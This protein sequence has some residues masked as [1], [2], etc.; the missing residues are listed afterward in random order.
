MRRLFLV[1]ALLLICSACFGSTIRLGLLADLHAGDTTDGASIV[2]QDD[3]FC[4]VFSNWSARLTQFSKVCVRES[5]DYA[6]LLGDII[7][8]WDNDPNTTLA[9][10]FAQ[11]KIELLDEGIGVIPL[12]G[13]HGHAVMSVKVFQVAFIDNCGWGGTNP[14]DHWPSSGLTRS[15][16]SF[17]R[18]VG[19]FTFIVVWGSADDAWDNAGV[20]YD[21]DFGIRTNAA[22]QLDWLENTS[23]ANAGTDKIIVL[24]HEHLSDRD[25]L[26]TI[27]DNVLDGDPD[28]PDDASN[29]VQTILTDHSQQ[30]V[31]FQ[32]HYHRVTSAGNSYWR[33]DTIGG[34]H[35]YSLRGSVLGRAAT[36]RRGNT[37]YI[38]DVDSA[39]GVISARIFKYHRIS[40][41]RYSIFDFDA[42]EG[43]RRRDDF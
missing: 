11:A 34:R 16:A 5:V 6:I 35:Y 10:V 32:G 23:L 30:V 4:R 19:D 29:P 26:A 18:D 17:R 9:A 40:R 28:A 27:D 38:V 14:T 31:V 7:D 37:F 22:S 12:V 25:G 24:S 8:R 36:D 20:D 43:V 2:A 41:D 33:D 21:G 1:F 39:A 3:G 13:N 42:L 15:Y